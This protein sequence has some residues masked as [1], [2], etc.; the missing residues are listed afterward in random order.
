MGYPVAN[1]LW[2]IFFHLEY[3]VGTYVV[4][5]RVQFLPQALLKFDNEL[6]KTIRKL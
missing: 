1:S 4:L 3:N 2:C 5:F 6:S